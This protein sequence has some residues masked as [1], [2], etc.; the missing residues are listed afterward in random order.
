[1]KSFPFE[2]IK[3]SYECSREIINISL[4]GLSIY[5]VYQNLAPTLNC[6]IDFHFKMQLE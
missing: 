1:M 3:Y 2:K 5:I 4:E 6:S